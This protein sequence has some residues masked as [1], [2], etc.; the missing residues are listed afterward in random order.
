[1]IE[2][3]FDVFDL[4][5]RDAIKIGSFREEAAD[6]AVGIF[7]GSLFPRMIRFTEVR[8]G[9]DRSVEQI[10]LCVFGAIVVSNGVT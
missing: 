10:M 8:R 2:P 4:R 5:L 1:M 3:R 7:H 9:S 6:E